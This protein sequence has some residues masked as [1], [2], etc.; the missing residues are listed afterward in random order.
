MPPL[1]N[2][3]LGESTP[4]F[5]DSSP[6][7]PAIG[8]NP[9]LRDP[10][11]RTTSNLIDLGETV[12]D[13]GPRTIQQPIGTPRISEETFTTPR[14]TSNPT[15]HY[16]T[17]SLSIYAQPSQ[18]TRRSTTSSR[19]TTN[20]SKSEYSHNRRAST[21]SLARSS[22]TRDPSTPVAARRLSAN[23]LRPTQGAAHSRGLAGFAALSR[24]GTTLNR[25][26]AQDYQ[27]WVTQLS[28]IESQP[29]SPAAK[30]VLQSL[31]QSADSSPTQV[32]KRIFVLNPAAKPFASPDPKRRQAS[33]LPGLQVEIEAFSRQVFET[34]IVLAVQRSIHRS[35]SST[36]TAIDLLRNDHNENY[37]TRYGR[38]EPSWADPEVP[39][40]PKDPAFYGKNSRKSSR[41]SSGR[42]NTGSIIGLGV[43]LKRV[44]RRH[45]GECVAGEE[46]SVSQK[47]KDTE[48][49]NLFE[50]SNR[51]HISY[52]YPRGDPVTGSRTHQFTE[53]EARQ[54]LLSGSISVT[55]SAGLFTASGA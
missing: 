7:Q 51:Q 29:P 23:S 34:D 30:E 28:P 46:D 37:F 20:I 41:D 45:S 6:T 49:E 43:N 32:S 33:G 1:L 27:R 12:P 55:P 40:P 48:P 5:G 26:D 15:I 16:P 35:N 52:F 2:Q 44:A 24:P 18:P 47:I 39:S 13:L 17:P 19:P 25:P 9:R 8:S 53:P 14:A 54:Q 42:G 21:P 31:H 50:A 38:P 3:R 10:H 4:D 22:H 11:R 36:G